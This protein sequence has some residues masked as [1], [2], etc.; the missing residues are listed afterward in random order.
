MILERTVMSNIVKINI[1]LLVFIISLFAFCS[2]CWPANFQQSGLKV[3]QLIED[4]KVSGTTARKA[5]NVS[6]KL[7]FAPIDKNSLTPAAET[8]PDEKFSSF[9]NDLKLSFSCLPEKNCRVRIQNKNSSKA[10]RNI[11]FEIEYKTGYTEEFKSNRGNIKTILLPNKTLEWPTS[12]IFIK[13]PQDIKITLLTASAGDPS[14]ITWM[15]AEQIKS[16]AAAVPSGNHFKSLRFF[17]SEFDPMPYPER[18]YKKEFAAASTRYI[19]W[20]LNL[21]H[22]KP[23]K[24]IEYDV[25]AIWLRSDGSIFHRQTLQAFMEPDWENPYC[26]SS[27]GNEIAGKTWLPDIYRVEIHIG[28]EKI[29]DGT[30]KVY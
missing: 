22:P 13:P 10:Y 28:S 26:T 1:L 2:I 3:R 14:N 5:Q 19:N 20:E 17:E 4:G 18:E 25:E 24:K 11:V 29:A 15:K 23:G 6:F 8:P 27:V 7:A 16:Q 21:H 12:L 9:H 30:F